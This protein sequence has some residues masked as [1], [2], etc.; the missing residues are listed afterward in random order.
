MEVISVERVGIIFDI[1]PSVVKTIAS[2][3]VF[4]SSPLPVTSCKSNLSPYFYRK[5]DKGNLASFCIGFHMLFSLG[6][7][8]PGWMDEVNVTTIHFN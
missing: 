2:I 1:L 7:Y 8:F 5:C 3:I 4:E 6:I